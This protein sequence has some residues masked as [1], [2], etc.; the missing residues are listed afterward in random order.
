MPAKPTG[1]P[2]WSN[3][4]GY[5]HGLNDPDGLW[6]DQPATQHQLAALNR[7][8]VAVEP[9]ITKGAADALLDA[10]MREQSR[11]F[12]KRRQHDSG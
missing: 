10:A 6:R 7:L 12:G 3:W 4:A 8:N 9:G 11:R 5:G 1:R 2:F